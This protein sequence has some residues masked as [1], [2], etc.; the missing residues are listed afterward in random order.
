MLLSSLEPR[1]NTCKRAVLLRLN[2]VARR[3][4]WYPPGKAFA[5]NLLRAV[6][7]CLELVARV[8]ACSPQAKPL[9]AANLCLGSMD[10]ALAHWMLVTQGCKLHLEE[11]RVQQAWCQ[12]LGSQQAGSCH[13]R[14]SRR[15][16]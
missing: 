9:L 5:G 10:L 13:E 3:R 4:V 11:D 1:Q 12:S 7:L 14:F 16:C 2:L 8:R 15:R 6:L